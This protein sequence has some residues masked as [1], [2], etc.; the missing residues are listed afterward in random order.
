MQRPVADVGEA[1]RVPAV[2]VRAPRDPRLSRSLE[3]PRARVALDLRLLA[4]LREEG[5]EFVLA[6]RERAGEAAKPGRERYQRSNKTILTADGRSDATFGITTGQR[7]EIIPLDDPADC[8]PGSA[9]RVKLLFAGQPL[10]DAKVRAWNR[11]GE[12][13]T[14]LDGRTSGDGEVAFA[15][16]VGGQWMLSTIRMARVTGD[17]DADWESTWGNLTF[18]IRR[19]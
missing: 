7:L 8:R 2:P 14:T 1:D 17:K 13:L 16:P 6:E 19:K 3:G 15:L 10:A 12:N 9:L 4:Q 11:T 5:L 18:A